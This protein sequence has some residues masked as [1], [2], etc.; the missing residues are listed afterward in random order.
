MLDFYILSVADLLVIDVEATTDALAN[1]AF[2]L[3]QHADT[4][5]L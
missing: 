2:E 5:T 3:F 1:R 4:G